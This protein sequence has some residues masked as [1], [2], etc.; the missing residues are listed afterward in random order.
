VITLETNNGNSN[1][2]HISNEKFFY[3]PP[4]T[5]K[6]FVYIILSELDRLAKNAFSA[7]QY[8]FLIHNE[9]LLKQITGI[10]SVGF[11]LLF[12]ASKLRTC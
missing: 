2:D 10:F 12:R 9:N 8:A 5:Q 1:V 11:Y 7:L 4:N 6:R 3:Y